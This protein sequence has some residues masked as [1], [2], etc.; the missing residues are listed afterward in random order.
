MSNYSNSP[1][2]PFFVAFDEGK[3]AVLEPIMLVECQAPLEFH[4]Q[5]LS[6]VTRRNGLIVDTDVSDTHARVVAEV[7]INKPFPFKCCSPNYL[8][9]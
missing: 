1:S 6:S 4:G 8:R 3:W 5:M 2:L 7:G 9:K